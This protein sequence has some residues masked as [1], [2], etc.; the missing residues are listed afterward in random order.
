MQNSGDQHVPVVSIVDDVTLDHERSHVGAELRS[1]TTH[2]RLFGQQIES[3]DYGVNESV[4]SGGAGVL[5]DVRPDLLEVPLGERGQPPGRLRF[6]GA[7][8]T[9]ARLDLLGK[10]PS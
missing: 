3:V 7:S 8:R 10:F 1:K 5:C 6:L 2:P 9:S 4:G